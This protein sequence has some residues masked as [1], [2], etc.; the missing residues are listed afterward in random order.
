MLK[1]DPVF[2]LLSIQS[3]V[4]RFENLAMYMKSSG[5]LHVGRAVRLT[6]FIDF[7]D[8]LKRSENVL[9]W[10]SFVWIGKNGSWNSCYA[11]NILHLRCHEQNISFQMLRASQRSST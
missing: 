5:A 6:L 3:Y 7:R 1:F 2:K 9:P 11:S 4:S 10:N 8:E